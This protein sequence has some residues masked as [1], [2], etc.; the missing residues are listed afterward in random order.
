MR[1]HRI[2][3]SRASRHSVLI[4]C[5]V[6]RLR[7]FRL[8]ADRV[9]NLSEGGLLAGSAV[10]VLTGE[11]LIVSFRLPD[12]GVWIDAN[13]TVARVLHGRR[14][15]D[16]GR[17]LGIRFDG[18]ELA[19]RHWLARFLDRSV[20]TAPCPRPGRRDPTKVGHALIFASGWTRFPTAQAALPRF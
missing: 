3:P 14:P 9:L 11:P 4:P 5:Q 8:V 17:K 19:S 20:A 10:P 18:I 2:L 13:A 15:G 1:K 16:G 6:V 12:S 7:D